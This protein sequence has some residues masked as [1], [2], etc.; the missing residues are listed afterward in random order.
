MTPPTPIN[1]SG[2]AE[3]S[4]SFVIHAPHPMGGAWITKRRIRAKENRSSAVQS[5]DSYMPWSGA[6]PW[7]GRLTPSPELQLSGSA[8][9]MTLLS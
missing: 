9:V 1:D 4:T 7:Y 5:C 3:E 8:K 6:E 2:R